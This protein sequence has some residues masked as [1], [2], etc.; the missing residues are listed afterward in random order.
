MVLVQDLKY[1]FC[2]QYCSCSWASSHCGHHYDCVFV[3]TRF[4]CTPAAR[5]IKAEKRLC[6]IK[7]PTPEIGLQKL[8]ACMLLILSN[9]RANGWRM[10][11]IK[12]RLEYLNAF[13]KCLDFMSL[14]TM[15]CKSYTCPLNKFA[16]VWPTQ[17]TQTAKLVVCLRKRTHN[18]FSPR[19]CDKVKKYLSSQVNT[20]VG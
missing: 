7:T 17:S 11:L 5:S 6:F 8:H 9:S 15:K 14:N 12:Q 20:T 10:Q 4:W 3:F 13:E 18:R 2:S 1:T 19:P 16:Y